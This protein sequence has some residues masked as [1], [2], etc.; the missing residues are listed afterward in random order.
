METAQIIKLLLSISSALILL[1]VSAVAYFLRNLH[2][3][4]DRVEEKVNVMEGEFKVITDL[5]T[6]S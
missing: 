5:I 2:I 4:L 3:K 1:I 6:R